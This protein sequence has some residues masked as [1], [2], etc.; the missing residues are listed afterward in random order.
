MTLPNIPVKLIAIL[1]LSA[2]ALAGAAFVGYNYRDGV[3]AKEMLK[4]E[5]EKNEEIRSIT[6]KYNTASQDL[7]NTL[8]RLRNLKPKVITKLVEI[9]IEKP[10]YNCLL[11]T[12]GLRTHETILEQYRSARHSG[13]SNNPLSGS[14]PASSPTK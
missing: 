13:K 10:D 9:E 3:A 1:V 14:P 4:L 2:G 12:D 6:L 8:E 11:P 7:E 5:A